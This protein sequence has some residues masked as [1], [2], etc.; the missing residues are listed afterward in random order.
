MAV[1]SIK[2]PP[3]QSCNSKR[4]V[5]VSREH[6]SASIKNGQSAGNTF[7]LTLKIRYA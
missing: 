2:N 7:Y 3:S 1:F 6:N 5:V 4:G